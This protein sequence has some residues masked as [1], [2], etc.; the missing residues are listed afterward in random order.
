VQAGPLSQYLLDPSSR[1]YFRRPKGW[2]PDL[3]QRIANTAYAKI[4]CKYAN[5]LIL[6]QTA[7]DT[8]LGHFLNVISRGW[9]HAFLSKLI[10]RPNEFICSTLGAYA[11]ASQPEFKGSGILKEP[12]AAIDPQKLFEADEEFDPTVNDCSSV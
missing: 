9:I 8:I 4:G 7:A 1:V 11:L 12:L 10:A 2:T 3:G 6:E 5:G